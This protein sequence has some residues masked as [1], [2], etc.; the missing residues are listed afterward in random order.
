LARKKILAQK[1]EGFFNIY[2]YEHNAFTAI[3]ELLNPL[4][5]PFGL[6]TLKYMNNKILL[7][8]D[9]LTMEDYDVILANNGLSD[10]YNEYISN[11]RDSSW[12]KPA[13]EYVLK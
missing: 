4:L 5:E 8:V 10:E 7:T 9:F 13:S 11:K 1:S 6:F 3:E 2:S 12:F